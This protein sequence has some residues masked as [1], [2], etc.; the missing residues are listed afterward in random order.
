MAG[1]SYPKQTINARPKSRGPKVVFRPAPRARVTLAELEVTRGAHIVFS[2]FRVRNET[3]NRAGAHHIT[4]RRIKMQLFFIR[5]A[6]HIS[7]IRS[8]VGPNDSDDYMNWITAPYDSNDTPRHIL[9]NRVRIYG[10]QKHNSGAHVDCIGIDDVRG[11]RILNSRIWDCEHFAIIF[12]KDL[13]NRRAARN[14]LLQ[15]NFIDCCGD[16]YYSLGLGDVEGPMMIRFNSLTQGIGWLGGSVRRVTLDSNVI[17][18][19]SSANC[20]KARW[21]Y[22]VV[23]RGSACRRGMRAR[24]GFR[25]PPRDLHLV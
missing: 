21:R 12:G 22:N 18:A 17:T 15:N 7:Y 20:N 19:N 24:T 6:D 4:Y 8:R 1:G 25:N 13:S 5:G 11:L 9:L 14:V 2:R 16:G 3:Y 23:A 10:F